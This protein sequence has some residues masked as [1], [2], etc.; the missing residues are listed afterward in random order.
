MED[1][2]LL[3]KIPSICAPLMRADAL[4]S[5]GLESGPARALHIVEGDP[6]L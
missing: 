5:D 1:L 6:G 4:P 3:G 2:S